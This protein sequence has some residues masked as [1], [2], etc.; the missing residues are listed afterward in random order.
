MAAHCQRISLT[1]KQ[2]MIVGIVRKYPGIGASDITRRLH[3]L[4]DNA[5]HTSNVWALR[6]LIK[7]N[8]DRPPVLAK[9]P[10]GKTPRGRGY[11][12]FTVPSP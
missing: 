11:Y 8:R 4:G 1:R 10:N 3:R 2:E 9:R 12:L 7:G 5:Q 6:L